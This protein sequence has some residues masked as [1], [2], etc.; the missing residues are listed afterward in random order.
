MKTN[1]L[2]FNCW[3]YFFQH[4]VL[5]FSINGIFLEIEFIAPSRKKPKLVK[6][7]ENVE[8]GEKGEKS[9]QKKETKKN[10]QKNNKSE[11]VIFV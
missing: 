4:V 2:P 5:C 9:K 10:K 3:N 1:N 6:D 7:K 11:V 8:N